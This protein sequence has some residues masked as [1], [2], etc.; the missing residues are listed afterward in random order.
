MNFPLVAYRSGTTIIEEGTTGTDIY[1]VR[2]GTLEVTKKVNQR[3]LILGEMHEGDIFGEMALFVE[4]NKRTAT[5]TAKTDV[6]VITINNRDFLDLID[7]SPNIIGSLIKGL[8]KKLKA[9]TAALSVSTQDKPLV[10]VC[11]ILSKLSMRKAAEASH[12]A[13]ETHIS[14]IEA[15]DSIMSILFMTREEVDFYLNRAHALK[16]IY[17]SDREIIIKEGKSLLPKVMQTFERIQ[18]SLSPTFKQELFFTTV[19]EIAH[20]LHIPEP[21]L[22]ERIAALSPSLVAINRDYIERWIEEIKKH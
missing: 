10:S 11:A 15:Y 9:T 18:R 20:T 4:E 7:K 14:I 22:M 21:L 5:V 8:A 12:A 3:V 6:E 19:S 2:R 17:K 13:D 16:L 1:I